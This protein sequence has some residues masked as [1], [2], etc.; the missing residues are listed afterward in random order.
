L[1][2]RD[3]P[4]AADYS[5]P[6]VLLRLLVESVIDYAIFLLDPAGFITSWNEGARR[7]KGYEPEEI[8][9]KHFSLFYSPEEA[10]R[11]KPKH[12]LRVAAAEG[13]WEDEGWRFRKDGSRF[14]ARVVITALRN[15]QGETIGF[16]KVTRDLTERKQAEDAR[17]ELLTLER[18]A[19]KETEATVERLQ[20]IQTLTEAALV[21]LDL[22]DLLYTLLDRISELLAV[23][24]VAVLLLEE[25][26]RDTL[27]AR[28]AK[29]IEEEVEQGVRI[30]LGKGFAGRVAA[31][32][33][34]IVLDDVD[35]ADV[36][37]PLL[38]E[39]GIRS[40][41]GV[42]LVA[43]GRVMGTLHVGTLHHH[44]F[45]EDDVQFLQ[46]VADRVALAIDHARLIEIARAAREEAEIADATLRA[47]DEFLSIAAHELKTP[48]TSLQVG[49]QVLLRRLRGSRGIDP[50]ELERP[51]R[52]VER[53][54]MKLTHLVSQLLE[55]VRVQAG[56]FKLQRRRIDFSEL[57]RSVA[58][59]TQNLTSRHELIVTAPAQIWILGDALRLEQVVTNLLDNAI[60]FSLG[61]SRIDLELTTSASGTVK[62]IVRDTGLGVPIEHRSHLFERFYQAHGSEHR[63][64]M[65]LGLYISREIV[66]MHGGRISAE[67]PPEGGTNMVVELPSGENADE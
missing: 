43:T 46:I 26:D 23:D 50:T 64:G 19:R 21:H 61:G 11:G 30:P 56:Q 44:R 28:A 59:T 2:I 62:L 58:E 54:S 14:W 10:S 63:S 15:S 8:I 7:I 31:E 57:V 52:T 47:R 37:N 20:S 9:G 49:V 66:E 5:Q 39:K 36:L 40:L 53:Q 34:A 18:K 25:P 45:T 4:R 60:K 32:Q 38:R 67:F 27:V 22:D 17:S 65:G 33:R 51:L 55:S 41:L 13:H 42:P 6:D 48:I 29:G 12:A 3:E 24:T 35:H 16:G 1:T